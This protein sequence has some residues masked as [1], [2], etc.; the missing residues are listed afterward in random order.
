MPTVGLINNEMQNK[1][2]MRYN[3]TRKMDRID[4]IRQ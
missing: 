2:Y 1:A 3:I 4:T